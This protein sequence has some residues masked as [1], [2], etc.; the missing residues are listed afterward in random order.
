MITYRRDPSGPSSLGGDCARDP[1]RFV[2]IAGRA[3]RHAKAADKR[4]RLRTR[5]AKKHAENYYLKN[6]YG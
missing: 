2:P 1:A 4:E 5:A 3:R 6:R